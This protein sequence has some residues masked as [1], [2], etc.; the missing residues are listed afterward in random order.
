MNL[1]AN[2]SAGGNH[3]RFETELQQLKDAGVNMLRIMASSEG[4]PTIQPAR[5][6]P[7]LMSAP[8]EWNEDIF[9]GLDRCMAKIQDLGMTAI[10][11]LANTWEWSG[12]FGQ[13]VSWFNGN[14]TIPYPNHWDPTLNAP[15][16]AY[17]TNGTTAEAYIAYTTQFYNS[18]PAQELY[19]AHIATVANRTNTVN[20]MLYKEDPAILAWELANEPQFPPYEW[21]DST[22]SYIKSLGVKQLVT[23]GFDGYEGEA[24]WKSVHSSPNIDFATGHWYPENYML[25]NPV[26]TS[27]ANLAFAKASLLE[28]LVNIS[29]WTTS[30]NKPAILEEFGLAR[31]LWESVALGAPTSSYIYNASSTTINR[32][33]FYEMAVNE[34]LYYF[35]SNKGIVGLAPWTYGG[36]FRPTDPVNAY[37]EKWAGDPPHEPPGWYDIYDKDNTTLAI[38]RS[39]SQMASSI[40]ASM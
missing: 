9:V 1:A 26:N 21:V 5:M 4:A 17:Q 7:A 13:Y 25:Y 18:T 22:A 28:F 33:S 19:R 34:V 12:G 6:Y 8:Y 29:D 3:S 40:I 37:N 15:Y 24:L 16:G 27:A 14:Q 31:D 11:D 32:D 23:A 35:E 2:A 36:I 20:G 38:L 10:L 30:L 39:Q